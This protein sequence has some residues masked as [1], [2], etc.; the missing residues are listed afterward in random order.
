MVSHTLGGV[1]AG[2]IPLN[3]GE[4]APVLE[5]PGKILET[6]TGGKGDF[7]RFGT[8]RTGAGKRTPHVPHRE[9]GGGQYT[10]H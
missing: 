4:K 2:E 3:W 6:Q 5:G 9:C 7:G 1:M 8:R 10:P